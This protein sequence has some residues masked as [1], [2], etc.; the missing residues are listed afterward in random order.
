MNQFMVQV[1]IIGGR[2]DGWKGFAFEKGTRIAVN[3][4]SLAA[5]FS[6]VE[7]HQLAESFNSYSEHYR[8]EVINEE[9]VVMEN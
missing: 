6:Q 5:K 3:L 2:F 1:T 7:A 9:D 8:A 4:F